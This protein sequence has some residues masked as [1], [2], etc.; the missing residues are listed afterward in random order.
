MDLG[1]NGEEDLGTNLF[2]CIIYSGYNYIFI[3]IYIYIYI[4]IL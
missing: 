3:Y 2:V 1:L 4:Y